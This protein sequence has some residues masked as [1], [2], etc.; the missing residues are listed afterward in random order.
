[1]T[2]APSFVTVFQLRAVPRVSSAF[3]ITAPVSLER[4]MP[5]G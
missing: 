1:V 2:S 3:S 4:P 5:S